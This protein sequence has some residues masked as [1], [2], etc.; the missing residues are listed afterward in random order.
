MTRLTKKQQA[1][2]ARRAAFYSGMLAALA[3]VAQHDNETIFREIVEL[4]DAA[5][6]VAFA[7]RDGQLECSGLV[8][9]GYATPRASGDGAEIVENGA[10]NFLEAFCDVPGCGIKRSGGS[11]WCKKHDMRWAPSRRRE[12]PAAGATEEGGTMQ[13]SCYLLIGADKSV[14]IRRQRPRQAA[15]NQVAIQ[16]TIQIDDAWFNRPIPAIELVVPD[17]AVLPVPTVAPVETNEDRRGW[18][19]TSDGEEHP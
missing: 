19:T 11:R 8:R 1:E 16:L 5:A 2:Q 7:R 17:A 10:H 15:L 18:L 13:V 3:V 9:Y 4:D 12:R 14:Q 6:L